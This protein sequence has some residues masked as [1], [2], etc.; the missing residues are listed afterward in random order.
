MKVL[1]INGSPHAGGCIYTALS[2][3][4]GQLQ[5]YGVETEIFQIGKEPVRGCI[6][7]KGCWGKGHCVFDDKVN[8]CIDK[9][10]EADGLVVGSPVYFSGITGSLKCLLD[11]V[12]YDAKRLFSYKPAAAVVSLS[13]IHIYRQREKYREGSPLLCDEL[14]DQDTIRERK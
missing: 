5:K 14:W 6:D 2:E 13:L 12:F 11:R 9:I 4:A 1:L 3:F 7:C 10:I 8:V